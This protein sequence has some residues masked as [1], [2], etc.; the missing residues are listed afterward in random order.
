LI[1][2]REKDQHEERRESRDITIDPLLA[3]A[4]VWYDD[5]LEKYKESEDPDP[6]EKYKERKR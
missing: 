1:R 4:Q 2:R 3:C 6:L 5:P